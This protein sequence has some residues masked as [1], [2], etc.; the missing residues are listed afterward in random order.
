M[1]V[2]NMSNNYSS[3]LSKVES[4]A[5]KHFNGELTIIKRNNGW[6]A[7]FGTIEAEKQIVNMHLGNSIEDVLQS[8]LDDPIDA[9]G[10]TEE[11]Y[12]FDIHS[13]EEVYAI[14]INDKHWLPDYI[15][16][17]REH[18]HVFS[19]EKKALREADYLKKMP[20]YANF[21]FKVVKV[22]EETFIH[23]KKRIHKQTI[24]EL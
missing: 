23:S 2:L 11:D 4:Y 13:F 15:H 17:E 3:L 24:R 14:K 6:H 9:F 1:G 5:N 18:I 10:I 22:E 20:Q 12:P 21:D 8:L 7:C 19:T 16:P